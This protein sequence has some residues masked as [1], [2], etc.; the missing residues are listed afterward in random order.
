LVEVVRRQGSEIELLQ[1]NQTILFGLVAR[2]KDKMVPELQPAQR[3]RGEILKVLLVANDGKMFAKDARQ[4]M[5]LPENTFSELLKTQKDS[6]L[7]RHFHL[8]FKA[9]FCRSMD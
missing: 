4:Q 3:D 9:G 1:E 8:S 7:A 2:L 5:R 6:I